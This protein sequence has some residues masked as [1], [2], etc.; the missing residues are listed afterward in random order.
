MKSPFTGK[1]MQLLHEIRTLEFRKEAFEI[2][3]HFYK[4]AQTEAQFTTDQLDELNIR[5]VHNQY[6]EKHNLPF[7]D[8]I[9]EIRERYGLSAKKMSAILGFG[10]NSYGQ[11]E[12][13]EVPSH[14]NAKNIQL[15]ADAKN[16]KALVQLSDALT[17]KGKEKLLKKV[18]QLIDEQHENREHKAIR[19]YLLPFSLPNRY[20]GF[21]SPSL[22]R[23]AHMIIFFAEAMRPW[24]TKLNKLLFYADFLAYQQQGYSISGLQYRAIGMGPVPSQYD[25]LYEYLGKQQ[26]V[27]I[28]RIS[29]DDYEGMQFD[30]N[31]EHPFQPDLFDEQELEVL[32]VVKNRFLNVSTK[33]LIE[34]SH[35]ETAWLNNKEGYQLIDYQYAF[36]LNPFG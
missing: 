31:P 11:Y 23:L 28:S 24:K 7:P 21:R 13:G 25:S 6:R 1:P 4:C 27:K 22:E 3:Y 32:Q 26:F 29:F 14:S 17:A 35:L 20:T 30:A 36:E 33:G 2:V 5:Q 12:R 19:S 8:Q 15:A 34:I 18:E 16:F 10:P 9:R